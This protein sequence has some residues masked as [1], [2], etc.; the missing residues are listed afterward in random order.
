M[1]ALLR[2]EELTLAGLWYSFLIKCE[3]DDGLLYLEQDNS[4]YA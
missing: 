3:G 1:Q 2:S 4:Q